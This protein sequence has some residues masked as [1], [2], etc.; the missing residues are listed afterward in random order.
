MLDMLATL[1]GPSFSQIVSRER[2]EG[3]IAERGESV[4]AYSGQEGG[5]RG[6][7]GQGAGREVKVGREVNA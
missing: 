5:Q 1:E 6:R 4:Q 2:M 3:E 7:K